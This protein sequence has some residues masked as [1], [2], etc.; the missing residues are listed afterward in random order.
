MFPRGGNAYGQQ[1]YAAQSG[2]GQKVSSDEAPNWKDKFL[3]LMSIFLKLSIFATAVRKIVCHEFSLVEQ[4]GSLS[5]SSLTLC[6]GKNGKLQSKTE[7]DRLV[8][9]WYSGVYRWD[10]RIFMG[11]FM[12]LFCT[13]FCLRIIND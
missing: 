1:S 6:D 12:N 11:M 9:F 4:L 10:L 7:L 8:H 5:E 2:Y 13:F 3:L